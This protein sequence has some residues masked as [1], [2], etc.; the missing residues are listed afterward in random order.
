[1]ENFNFYNPTRI[2]FGKNTIQQ[3]GI[4][5]KN[6]NINSVLLLAGGG[7]IK[8]NNVFDTVCDSLKASN[9]KYEC[10]FGVRPNP[11]VEHAREGKD[12]IIKNNLQAILAV[13]G[14]SVIDE[15]KAIGVG[16][17]LDD[18]WNAFNKSVVPTQGLPVYTILTLSGTGTESNMN[19][20]LSNEALKKKLSL[21]SNLNFPKLSIIDPSVQFSLP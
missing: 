16:F 10:H 13:G 9:I 2:I 7:S 8:E 17:Y 19:A 11:T 12:I 4:E 3:I 15:G 6:A 20:V 21:Y 14:G 1:M 18:I 5:L